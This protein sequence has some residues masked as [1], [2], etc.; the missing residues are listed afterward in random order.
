MNIVEKFYT[1]FANLDEEGMVACYADDI[2]FE[3]PAFGI[4]AGERAKNMWRMLCQSQKGQNF[5]VTF[6]EVK[7]GLEDGHANWEAEYI[8][9]KTGRA[10]HNKISAS[11][12]IRDGLIVKHIDVFDLH[13]WAKQALGFKGLLLGGTRF[14][15]RGLQKQTNH[16]LARYEQSVD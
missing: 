8:F 12:E 5:K 7:I 3:D 4:L 13:K 14:F 11:F 6:S 15:K 1:A 10:V 9:S 16:M 2:H